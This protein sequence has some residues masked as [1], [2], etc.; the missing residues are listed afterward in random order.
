ML[1]RSGRGE[2][3]VEECVRGRVDARGD[4]EVQSRDEVCLEGEDWLQVCAGRALVFE[5]GLWCRWVSS[6]VRFRNKRALN[7]PQ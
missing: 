5:E 2:D 4:G 3:L 7:A 1:F 6:R